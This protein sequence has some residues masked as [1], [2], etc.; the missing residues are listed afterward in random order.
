ME[1]GGGQVSF[2]M[3][4]LLLSLPAGTVGEFERALIREASARGSG[5]PSRA[6]L[7]WAGSPPSPPRRP[8]RSGRE[9]PGL[10]ISPSQRKLGLRNWNRPYLAPYRIFIATN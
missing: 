6:G 8:R 10:W 9:R 4:N 2:T 7:T 3:A 1:P 5:R